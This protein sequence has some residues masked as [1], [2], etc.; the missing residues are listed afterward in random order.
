MQR[1]TFIEK[2]KGATNMQKYARGWA[3]RRHVRLQHAAATKVQTAFRGYII[4]Q[5]YKFTVS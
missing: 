1:Q 3:V 2:V 5:S 4:K